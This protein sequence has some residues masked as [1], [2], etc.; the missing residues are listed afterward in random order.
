MTVMSSTVT[1]L[2]VRQEAVMRLA[3]DGLADKE[4]AIE[5][6]LSL[7]TLRTYWDRMRKKTDSRSRS[8]II[9]KISRENLDVLR[10]ELDLQRLLLK[11]LPHALWTV[12]PNGT[13]DFWNDWFAEFGGM[14]PAEIAKE[15][16]RALMLPEDLPASATRWKQALDTGQPY[17]TMVRLVRAKD[18]MVHWHDLRLFPLRSPE[19]I[20]EKWVGSAH[21]IAP[22]Y[23]D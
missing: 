4:I 8:E 17:S 14:S 22:A 18:R 16:C 15:G 9:A 20:I 6:G 5:L 12:T 13:F 10:R 11:G 1:S 21:P 19:G 7:G 2:S 3:A 23:M